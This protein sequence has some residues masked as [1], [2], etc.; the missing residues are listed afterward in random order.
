[1]IRSFDCQDGEEKTEKDV[2]MRNPRKW[3]RKKVLMMV[4]IRI[5]SLT[6]MM[7]GTKRRKYE[8][9]LVLHGT[10]GLNMLQQAKEFNDV[11]GIKGFILT[12]L[13]RTAR[14][15]CVVSVNRRTWSSSQVCWRRRRG[16]DLQPFDAEAFV[17]AIFP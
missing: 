6:T 3:K 10:T 11:V 8:I 16:E 1:M 9:L 12:K 4:I 5:S 17:E 14:V 7:I 15:G 13:D 2:D